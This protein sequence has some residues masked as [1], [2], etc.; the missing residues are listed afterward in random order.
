MESVGPDRTWRQPT[1]NMVRPLGAPVAKG[2]P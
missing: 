1:R 2:A